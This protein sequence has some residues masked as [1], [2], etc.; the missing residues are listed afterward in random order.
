M[1]LDNDILKAIHAEAQQQNRLIA[2]YL[3]TQAHK[4]RETPGV[5]KLW[6]YS[7]LNPTSPSPIVVQILPKNDQRKSVAITNTGIGSDCIISE[8]W[9]DPTTVLQWF[10]DASD[11]SPNA[12]TANNVA[13]P[14][15][16]LTNGNSVTLDGTMGIWAYSLGSAQGTPLAS[17]L[18]IADSTYVKSDPRAGSQAANWQASELLP[19]EQPGGGITK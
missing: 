4:A 19:S 11:P 5:T 12:V 9:F 16:F 14:I 3:T 10:S 1:T 8:Q 6:T 15:G 13:I 18:S 17:I 7:L 2:A